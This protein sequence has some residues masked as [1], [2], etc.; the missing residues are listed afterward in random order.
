[1]CLAIPYKIKSIKN[2]TALADAGK[3]CK[4]IDTHLVPK[5]KKGDWVLA[6]QN[7]AISKI[8]EKDALKIIRLND[9]IKGDGK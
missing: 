1:M 4:E 2:N 8:T 7:F 5:L 6:N 9:E 3:D